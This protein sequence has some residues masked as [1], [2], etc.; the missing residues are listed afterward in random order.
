MGE[1]EGGEVCAK[2]SLAVPGRAW[3][4][5]ASPGLPWP[6]LAVPGRAWPCMVVSQQALGPP[7]RQENREN[8]FRVLLE[9]SWLDFVFFLVAVCCSW[10]RLGAPA[11]SVRLSGGIWEGFGSQF[12]SEKRCFL[13]SIFLHVAGAV[14]ACFFLAVLR[15]Q[16]F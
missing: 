1:F 10:V 15:A 5:L 4:C 16:V 3:P 12:A 14:S 8:R 2:P 11:A 13:G 7:R 6:C 9:R